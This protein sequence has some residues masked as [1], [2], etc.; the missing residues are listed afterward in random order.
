MPEY[1]VD[2]PVR[3]SDDV[4]VEMQTKLRELQVRGYVWVC[5]CIWG[6]GGREGGK[7]QRVTGAWVGVCMGV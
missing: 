3:G 2:S 1:E 4:P 7:A 5:V 6:V